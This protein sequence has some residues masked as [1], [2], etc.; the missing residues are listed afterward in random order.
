M[1]N[2][3]VRQP[4]DPRVER[5]AAWLRVQGEDGPGL[6]EAAMR[7]LGLD[8]LLVQ[9]GDQQHRLHRLGGALAYEIARITHACVGRR[10]ACIAAAV[11]EVERA[12]AVLRRV[13]GRLDDGDRRPM[14]DYAR[15]SRLA[16]KVIELLT[17]AEHDERKR[18]MY[19]VR[20]RELIADL[21]EGL[22][23]VED[24]NPDDPLWAG[25]DPPRGTI[26]EQEIG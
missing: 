11:R 14:A 9:H 17:V 8:A 22:A 2:T 1:N 19:V 20:A 5:L 26:F 12:V 21:E 10:A 23:K 6:V 16:D 24:A 4:A 13:R 25:I 15:F 18:G 3:C 7:L